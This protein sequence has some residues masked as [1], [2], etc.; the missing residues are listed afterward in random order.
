MLKEEEEPSVSG[1]VREGYPEFGSALYFDVA[2]NTH[3]VIYELPQGRANWLW[4]APATNY[5]I[6]VEEMK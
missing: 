3:S 6:E 4:C 2:K 5:S 1:V